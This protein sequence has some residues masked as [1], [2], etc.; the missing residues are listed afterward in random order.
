LSFLRASFLVQSSTFLARFLLQIRR[1]AKK[2]VPTTAE[3]VIAAVASGQ[4][5]KE[6]ADG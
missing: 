3:R 6:E 4:D 1:P 2:T 5:L